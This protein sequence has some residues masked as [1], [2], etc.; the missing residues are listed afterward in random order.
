MRK[1]QSGRWIGGAGKHAGRQQCSAVQCSGGEANETTGHLFESSIDDEDVHNGGLG[2][3]ALHAHE[4]LAA[5]IACEEAKMLH[6]VRVAVTV[7]VSTCTGAAVP[8]RGAITITDNHPCAVQHNNT[9]E[10]TDNHL[11]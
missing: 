8:E 7:T 9:H 4:Y 5:E 3:V 2:G 1:W 6:C 11:C 10:H